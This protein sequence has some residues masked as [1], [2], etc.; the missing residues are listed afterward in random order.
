MKTIP[1]ALY[2]LMWFGGAAIVAWF[3]PKT[4]LAIFAVAAVV[5]IALRIVEKTF[6]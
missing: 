6:E 4:V 1:R 5:T 2:E 3:F